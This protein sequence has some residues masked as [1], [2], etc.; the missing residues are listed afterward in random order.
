LE[1]AGE[2]PA[3]MKPK[4]PAFPIQFDVIVENIETKAMARGLEAWHAFRGIRR[5]M[6]TCRGGPWSKP[7]LGSEEKHIKKLASKCTTFAKFLEHA[8]DPR[9]SPALYKHMLGLKFGSERG[10]G[11]YVAPRRSGP[12]GIPGYDYRESRIRDKKL[13]RNSNKYFELK[14]GKAWKYKVKRAREHC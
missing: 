1:R 7:T 3:F 12:S 6:A 8:K 13:K 2:P 10:Q 11:V 4:D 14:F 5:A 9:N